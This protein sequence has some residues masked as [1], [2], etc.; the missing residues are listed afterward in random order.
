MNKR[1]KEL[2]AQAWVDNDH[3]DACGYTDLEK[4]AQLLLKECMTICG[5]I[6]GAGEFKNMP[7]FAAGAEKCKA[8]IK[9]DF[10]VKE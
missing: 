3:L 8:V 10:G 1:I 9:R 5:A 4:F 2:A 7:D 6:Q